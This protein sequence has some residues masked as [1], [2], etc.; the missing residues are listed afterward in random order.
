[1]Y[2]ETFISLFFFFFGRLHSDSIG[3]SVS[4]SSKFPPDRDPTSRPSCDVHEG[5][6]IRAPRVEFMEPISGPSNAEHRTK[7]AGPTTQQGEIGEEWLLGSK[8]LT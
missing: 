5:T 3:V 1:M 6:G 4:I 7:I 8:H 2:S